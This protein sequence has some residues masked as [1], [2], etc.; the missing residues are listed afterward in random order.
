MTTSKFLRLPN[1]Q[2]IRP[3]MISSIYPSE[4]GVQLLN[5]SGNMIGFI[6][7]DNK[8]YHDRIKIEIC[9]LITN[10]CSYKSNKIIQIDWDGVYKKYMIIQEPY[11][12][13][14]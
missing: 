3:F 12:L 5:A 13:T 4:S 2:S 8:Q 14:V 10:A 11:P 6:E 9:D 1:G 7:I